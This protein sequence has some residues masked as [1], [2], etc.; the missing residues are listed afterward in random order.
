MDDTPTFI[1]EYAETDAPQ[2]FAESYSAW[3]LKL[4]RLDS[5]RE[6]FMDKFVVEL[7]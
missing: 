3:V 5:D 2:D 4:N 7:I 1:S 6:E